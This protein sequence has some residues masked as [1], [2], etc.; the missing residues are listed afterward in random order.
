VAQLPASCPSHQTIPGNSTTPTCSSPLLGMART[1]VT[2]C[3]GVRRIQRWRVLGATGKAILLSAGSTTISTQV[4]AGVQQ[5]STPLTVTTAE[6]LVFIA[7]PTDTNVSAVIGS[8]TGV[9]VKLFDNLGGPSCSR[10]PI[11][12]QIVEGRT[13]GGVG[14]PSQCPAQSSRAVRRRRKR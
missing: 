1:S 8:G 2:A 9:K 4:G 3:S 5:A 7:Q 10:C 6:L 13:A 11:D 12:L 14:G